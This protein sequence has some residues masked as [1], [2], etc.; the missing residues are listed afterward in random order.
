MKKMYIV[1]LCVIFIL[2]IISNNTL[3]E[4]IKNKNKSKK[5][6][7]S[8]KKSESS[9]KPNTPPTPPQNTSLS[10]KIISGIRKIPLYNSL[11]RG[12]RTMIE[13]FTSFIIFI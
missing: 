7:K 5:N 2:L 12:L 8:K 13:K 9:T 3:E 1:I 10:S 6:K 11:P 4:G